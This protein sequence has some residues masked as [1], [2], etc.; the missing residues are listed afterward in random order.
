MGHLVKGRVYW[1]MDICSRQIHAA[2]SFFSFFFFLCF[3]NIMLW[4]KDW[5]SIKR[6][7]TEFLLQL[8]LQPHCAKQLNTRECSYTSLLSFAD[9]GWGWRWGFVTQTMYN[10][11]FDTLI[12]TFS[13]TC[14]IMK[15][16][17]DPETTNISADGK[18]FLVAAH[19]MSCHFQEVEKMVAMLPTP[20]MRKRP[21]CLFTL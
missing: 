6:F 11:T 9:W 12:T 13:Q 4:Q 20:Q 17:F 16:T 1:R 21:G 2:P 5:L 18:L 7:Y 10:N 15:K 19:K 8:S 14:S 3:F